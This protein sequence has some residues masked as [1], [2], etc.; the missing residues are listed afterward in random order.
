MSFSFP[1]L[2]TAPPITTHAAKLEGTLHALQD[3]IWLDHDA[4]MAPVDHPAFG[5]VH[6]KDDVVS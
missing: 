2:I 1:K 5:V 3:T 6:D 4:V